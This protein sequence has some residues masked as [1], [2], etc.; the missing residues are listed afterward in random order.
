MSTKFQKIHERPH[1]CL[2]ASW[3]MHIVSLHSISLYWSMT[4]SDGK[5]CYL[6]RLDQFLFVMTILWTVDVIFLGCY[7]PR[8]CP[9]FEVSNNST[10]IRIMHCRIFSVMSWLFFIQNALSNTFSS[11]LTN[12]NRL[13]SGCRATDTPLRTMNCDLVLKPH[14]LLYTCMTFNL[15]R[16]VG[17]LGLI[18]LSWVAAILR[19][20]LNL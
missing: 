15:C 1:P 5:V 3:R 9:N 8:F 2:V 16:L 19:I 20:S 13:V 18:L 12:R 10:S 11:F 7:G 17:G 14:E 4:W 6:I